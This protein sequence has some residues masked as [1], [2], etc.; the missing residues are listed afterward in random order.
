[1]VQTICKCVP[2]ERRTSVLYS[3]PMNKLSAA[4]FCI[5]ATIVLLPSAALANGV[6]VANVTLQNINTTAHTVE[7]KFDLSQQN[8]YGDLTWNGQAFSD[9]IWITVKYATDAMNLPATGYQHAMLAAGGTITPTTDDLGAFV[10][11]ST[12]ATNMTVVWNY[13]AD[14]VSDTAIVSVKVLALETVKVPQGQF[15]YDAG[16]IGGSG[17]N[18]YGGGSQTDVTS[19]TDLPSGAAAGWPNGYGS[20]Y[21]AKYEVSQG[22]YADF[23]NML[24]NADASSFFANQNGNNGNTITYTGS[25]AYGFKYAA[26]VPNRGNNF[27]SWSDATGYASWLAMRPMTEMEFEKAAR[28]TDINAP[29][30]NTY[31]WGN[32][33]PTG[34]STYSYN[35]GS[36]N[37]TYYEYFANFSGGPG[38]PI[39]VGH[40]LRGDVTRTNAQT[41]A[42]PYGITDLAGNDWEHLINCASP[43]MPANGVGVLSPVP[44]SWPLASSGK[45]IRGGLW[46]NSASNLRVSDRSVAGWT[47]TARDNDFGFRPARTP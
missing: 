14:S 20:F 44:A 30:A 34:S 27:M 13:G 45:G 16:G 38:R 42:S 35:D 36:G 33:D 40:Y 11:A 26:S 8:A 47:S 12:A 28:G 31:P 23:L 17:N 29:N 2:L 6:A 41:G 1:M 5:A 22:Q 7:I 39:D 9:Y 43:S 3:R 19:A 15:T 21:L 25:N 46:D 10:K 4:A 32:G 18:N 24:S 37:A